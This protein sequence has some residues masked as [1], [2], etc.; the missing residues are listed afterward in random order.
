MPFSNEPITMVHQYTRSTL[1]DS[2]VKK[3]TLPLIEIRFQIGSPKENAAEILSMIVPAQ[4][5]GHLQSPIARESETI[6]GCNRPTP[7]L[8]Y[9]GLFVRDSKQI[10]NV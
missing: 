10:L 1:I 3:G 8:V 7:P 9:P 2:F 6:C 5:S 4:T